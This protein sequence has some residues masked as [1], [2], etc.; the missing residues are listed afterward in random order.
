MTESCKNVKIVNV[1]W[2]WDMMAWVS[3]LASIC[4]GP[5]QLSSLLSISGASV[6]IILLQPHRHSSYHTSFLHKTLP[7]LIQSKTITLLLAS[8]QIV[9]WWC[10]G[11]TNERPPTR[12]MTNE[13]PCIDQSEA[14]TPSIDQSEAGTTGKEGGECPEQIST[15]SVI[16]VETRF[17]YQPMTWHSPSSLNSLNIILL[18]L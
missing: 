17:Y 6:S 18:S 15:I 7:I 10:Q 16:N 2:K 5:L 8:S 1:C 4:F 3:V 14:S 13:R 11:E 12:V 9:M